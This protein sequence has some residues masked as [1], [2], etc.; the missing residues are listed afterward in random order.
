MCAHIDVAH[1]DVAQPDMSIYRD[2]IE[3][4]RL[5][6][7][8]KQQVVLHGTSSSARSAFAKL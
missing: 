1:I 7:S 5:L 4:L 8:G 3:L 6:P 2:E